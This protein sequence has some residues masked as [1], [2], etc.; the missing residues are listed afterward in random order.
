MR[1]EQLLD[2]VTRTIEYSPLPESADAVET[3]HDLE[4]TSPFDTILSDFFDVD[5]PTRNV[6]EQDLAT[7]EA[8]PEE[9]TAELEEMG[10]QIES[11]LVHNPFNGGGALEPTMLE[12]MEPDSAEVQADDDAADLL[13]LEEDTADAIQIKNGIPYVAD[14]VYHPHDD[15]GF[16]P[17]LKDL[18]DSV[19]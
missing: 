2:E 19:L 12:A 14:T 9:N 8:A 17:N 10:P 4:I 6:P 5:S 11:P 15:E 16:D 18:V 1:K 3:V 13:S 7:I